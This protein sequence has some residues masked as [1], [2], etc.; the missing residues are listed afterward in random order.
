LGKGGFVSLGVG[1]GALGDVGGCVAAG[2]GRV[3][4]GPSSVVG[5]EDRANSLDE[6]FSAMLL[7]RIEIKSETDAEVYKRAKLDRRLLR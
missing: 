1:E 2:C 4:E 3:E 5:L 7:R 6:S